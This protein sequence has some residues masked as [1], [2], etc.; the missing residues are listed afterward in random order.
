[1]VRANYQAERTAESPLPQELT[2]AIKDLNAT[3]LAVANVNHIPIDCNGVRRIE[4]PRTSALHSPTREHTPV[5]I[6]LQDARISVTIGDI[7]VSVPVPGNI[8]GLVEM[9]DI[10]AGNA[11]SSQGKQNSPV[12]VEL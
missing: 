8:R 5:P 4:L 6:E 7:D 2:I 9:K 11:H 1:M 12:R 10:V 3:V